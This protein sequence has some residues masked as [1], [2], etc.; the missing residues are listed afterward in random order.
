MPCSYTIDTTRE[1]VLLRAEGILADEELNSLCRDIADDSGYR[2]EFRFFCDL[3]QVTKN[4]LSANSLGHIPKI[5]KHSPQA[6]CVILFT[7]RLLDFGMFRMYEAYC[8][9]S[10]FSVPRCFHSREEALACLN[11]GVPQEKFVG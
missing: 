1:V 6:R 5:L 10:G 3:T 2:P 8:M 11:E 7:W 4:R 9:V